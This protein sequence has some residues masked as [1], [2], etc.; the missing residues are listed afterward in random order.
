MTHYCCDQ[1]IGR[2]VAEKVLHDA[3]APVLGGGRRGQWEV[4]GMGLARQG[5][6][7]HGDRLKMAQCITFQHESSLRVHAEPCTLQWHRREKACA[8]L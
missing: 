7:M 6:Q 5:R 1:I 3:P 2:E 8:V 4:W